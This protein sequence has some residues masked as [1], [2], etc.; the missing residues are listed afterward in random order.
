MGMGNAY[1][2][3]VDNVEALFYNPA[4]L[5]KVRGIQLD[6]LTLNASG[7]SLDYDRLR[8]LSDSGADLSSLVSPLYGKN[9]NY[10][11]MGR[12][13]LAMP[14]LG[15]AVYS[16]VK[17]SLAV[18]NPPY[19]QLD[20]NALNDYG[21]ALGFGVPVGPFV[22]LGMEGRYIKRTGTQN[23]YSGGSLANLSNDQI[24]SDLKAWGIGYEFDVGANFLIP[25]P[26]ATFDFSIVWQN[27]GDTAFK[28]DATNHIPSEPAN[29]VIGT[30]ADIRLPL[31]TIRP[32]LDVRHVTD[33]D[34]QLF[35]KINFGVEIGLP[36][37]DIRGGFSE[38]YFTYGAGMSFGPIRV[39]AASYA[40]ELGDYP[41]QIEDRRYMAQVTIEL[42]V[43]SFGVDDSK[44]DPSAK[45]G[46]G[47]SSSSGTGG[48]R[49]LKE[50]R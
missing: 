4:S 7:D 26:M 38:G 34:I 49:R 17:T 35:R 16:S 29:L 48:S 19:T 9:F 3:V 14:M 36:L 50:R 42:D 44:N 18:H 6:L 2:G 10:S 21:Y 15:A 27:I 28:Q 31:V 12:A 25:I 11:A 1:I 46:K 32:A 5:A 37:L 30:A 24:V 8:D 23:I 43:G 41:G 39:D 40:A 13:G 22:Q 45:G 20:V 47:S 33:E